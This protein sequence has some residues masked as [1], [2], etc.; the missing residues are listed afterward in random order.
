MIHEEI[1]EA[2]AVLT[3]K[4]E[5]TLSGNDYNDIIWLSNDPQP[6][7]AEIEAEIALIP[8]RKEKAKIEAESNKAALLEKLGITEDEAKLLLG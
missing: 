5:W 8:V 1:I 3:P 7:L 6:S 4:A 2:L